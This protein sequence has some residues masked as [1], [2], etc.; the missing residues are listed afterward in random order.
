MSVECEVDGWLIPALPYWHNTHPRAF[1]SLSS[2]DPTTVM[3]VRNTG[4]YMS[5]V[6]CRHVTGQ[7]LGASRTASTRATVGQSSLCG[8][9]FSRRG[10]GLPLSFFEGSSFLWPGLVEHCFKRGCFQCFLVS[11]SSSEHCENCVWKL[12][13]STPEHVGE[14]RHLVWFYLDSLTW[15]QCRLHSVMH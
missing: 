10:G 9:T 4:V 13:D 14:G 15:P 12:C 7:R 3:R 6:L 5:Y 11:H 8:V 2:P 1:I